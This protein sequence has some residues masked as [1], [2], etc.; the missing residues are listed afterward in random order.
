MR[1]VVPISPKERDKT[2]LNINFILRRTGIRRASL[3]PISP[4]ERG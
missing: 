4:K 3:F 1:L 2:D